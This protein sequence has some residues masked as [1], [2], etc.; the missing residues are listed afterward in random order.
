MDA[1]RLARAAR[2][3]LRSP[4]DTKSV[5]A[6]LGELGGSVRADR[7]YVFEL[8]HGPGVGVTSSQ[9]FEW[10]AGDAAPQ[11][12]NPELQGIRVEELF[13][14]WLETLGRGEPY[15]GVVRDLPVADQAILGPQDVLSL[16]VCPIRVQGELWGFV[17]FDDCQR[18]REWSPTERQVLSGASVALAAALRHRDV[19]QRL[20][21][22]RAALA[23]ALDAAT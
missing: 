20:S 11:I 6:Y 7:A 19:Q 9:R 1:E 3:L 8:E 18:E 2:A 14:H 12:D 21:V 13:A 4:F 23:M 22:A 5:V 10:N 16:L 17:G 15:F